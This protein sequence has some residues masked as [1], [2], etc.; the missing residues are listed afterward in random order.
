MSV[1]ATSVC[2]PEAIE[3]FLDGKL[4]DVEIQRFEHHLEI[5]EACQQ[6][7]FLDSGGQDLAEQ[8]RSHLQNDFASSDSLADDVAA[9]DKPTD[10][11][12]SGVETSKDG[13]AA[14]DLQSTSRGKPPSELVLTFL[15]PTDDPRMMGRFGGYEICGVIGHGG[16]GLVLK[17][18]DVSLDRYVAIKVLH[19]SLSHK[20]DA[21]VRFAR[22][23]QAAAAVV[24]DNVIG[25]HGVD[26]C[27][28]LPY[29][30]MPYINGTSLQGRIDAEGP[31]PLDE[32]LRIS[33]QVARGLAAAHDQGLIHRDIKPGNI[34]TPRSVSRVL[35]TDFGL[36]RS[37]GES[38]LTRTGIVAGTPQYMSPEQA[39]GA[40]V[41]KRTD[42][43]SVG[44]VMYAMATGRPPF[45][46]DS[47]YTVIRQI[48]D[49]PHASIIHQRS[50]LP[51]WFSEIV[52][53]LLAK[54]PS[55][56]FESAD[57]LA[58][59][60]EECLAHVQQ[61][62]TVELPRSLAPPLA[63]PSK[64]TRKRRIPVAV[65]I[66][67]AAVL[68]I[69]LGLFVHQSRDVQSLD[70]QGLDV[71]GRDAVDVP[72]ESPLSAESIASVTEGS[73]DPSAANA[74]FKPVTEPSLDLELF[75]DMEWSS[76]QT[77]LE[78][79]RTDPLFQTVRP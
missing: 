15:N 50:D 52:D 21:I 78:D 61:P 17:G 4:S 60:L 71:R 25:I 73:S 63:G 49:T 34:L 45:V 19:P 35:I 54:Q 20:E 39:K 76:M 24:H 18:L 2:R 47:A 30:V 75:D 16:A 29:L 51:G 68:L 48:I 69:G 43:F 5:C 72:A 65:A 10:T 31:M 26:R 14:Q 42:L 23:A 1:K 56:R 27:N 46:G 79:F 7:L 64:P 12:R 37:V 57:E 13:C 3:R 58:E 22:E 66:A 33:L 6:R 59:H 70:V 32:M 77:T 8:L 55:D 67:L 74:A 38:E 11:A 36:A 53:R 9:T 44:G 40:A 28:G 62:Q 41:D